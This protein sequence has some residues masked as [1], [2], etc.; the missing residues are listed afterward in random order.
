MK[1]LI[2]KAVTTGRWLAV[3]VALFSLTISGAEAGYRLLNGYGRGLGKAETESQ[4]A[5]LLPGPPLPDDAAPGNMK[6]SGKPNG[7]PSA[8]LTASLAIDFGS[9]QNR[10]NY[11]CDLSRAIDAG[12][13]GRSL[14]RSIKSTAYQVSSRLG[15][16]FTLVGAK[17]SGTS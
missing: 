12:E 5:Q 1:R 11:G 14:T 7:E 16:Q 8:Y 15:I 3:I 13:S 6:P 2:R 17:P 10:I 9:S 4:H